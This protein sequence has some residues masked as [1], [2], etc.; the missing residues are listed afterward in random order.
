MI[1]MPVTRSRLQGTG[2]VLLALALTSITPSGVAQELPI[3]APGGGCACDAECIY[4]APPRCQ[5]YFRTEGLALRRDVLEDTAIATSAPL[6]PSGQVVLSRD[7]LGEPFS[8]GVRFL[9]GHTFGDSPYQIEFSYFTLHQ[10]DNS[11]GVVDSS[12][13]V[14]GTTGT[15]FS[16]FTH[17]GN[18]ASN[19]VD[20]NNSV[21]IHEVSYL[22]NAEINVKQAID[23]PP[24]TALN[25]LV[26][27]RH[28]GLRETFEYASQPVPLDFTPGNPVGV[29]THTRNDLWGPQIGGLIEM[30]AAPNAWLSFEIKGAIC[31]NSIS[32]ELDANIGGNLYDHGRYVQNSTAYVADFNLSLFWRPTASLTTRFGYQALWING[33]ALASENS[34]PAL[35]ELITPLA[36][37]AINRDGTVLYHGPYAGME[38]S[39]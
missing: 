38:V 16:A 36:P 17:F 6:L 15:L 21:Q 18:P 11:A 25:F 1:V 32:R 13:I 3:T 19:L 33:L 30:G 10:W 37:I 34:Q 23:M 14:N 31:N 29:N 22:D 9:V 26:G 27:V 20:F 4:P 24:G 28:V 35:G 2:I 12:S 8:A 5:W 7:D 39:W